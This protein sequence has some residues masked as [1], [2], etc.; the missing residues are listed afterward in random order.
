MEKHKSCSFLGHRKINATEKLKEQV[1]EIAENLIVA[2]GVRTF[3]FGSRSEFNSL[4]HSVVSGLKE[5]YPYIKRI[6][7]T[8]KSETCVLEEE[9]KKW[10]TIFY[11]LKKEKIF[12][13][14]YEEEIEHK[15]KQTAGKAS[16]IERNQAMIDDSD[17][18]VF[19]FDKNYQV[20]Y[21]KE[22]RNYN[23]KSGTAIAYKY[24]VRK[25]KRII[26]LYI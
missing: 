6:V 23:I 2:Y 3:L 14:G 7:Y 13:L 20:T 26:N 24:A 9:R 19:Y 11:N 5:K 15:T 22:E 16:Y 18:C 12:L 21:G 17:Y 8:C 10:E 1:K 25:Q 4:C